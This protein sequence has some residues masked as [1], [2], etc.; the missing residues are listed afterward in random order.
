MT[1]IRHCAAFRSYLF[2][3]TND[4]NYF[5]AVR[6]KKCKYLCFKIKETVVKTL[7]MV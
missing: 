7:R 5:I 3:V 1:E 4:Y 6:V 2:L